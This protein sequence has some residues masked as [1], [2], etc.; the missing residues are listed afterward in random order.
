[1]D[2]V[3]AKWKVA[4]DIPVELWGWAVFSESGG[5]RTVNLEVNSMGMAQKVLRLHEPPRGQ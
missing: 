4:G 2:F 3:L 1:M 5:Q